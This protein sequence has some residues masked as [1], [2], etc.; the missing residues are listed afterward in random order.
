MVFVNGKAFVLSAVLTIALWPGI[1]GKNENDNS[2]ALWIKTARKLQAHEFMEICGD[3]FMSPDHMQQHSYLMSDFAD[4]VTNMCFKIAP[5]PDQGTC[6]GSGFGSLNSSLQNA[7]FRHA[8]QHMSKKQMPID[9]MMQ[10]GDA[11]YIVSDKTSIE[12]DVMR[13]DLCVEVHESIGD[14]F[15]KQI[16]VSNSP[17]QSGDEE[18]NVASEQIPDPDQVPDQVPVPVPDQVLVP[19]KT[20]LDVDKAESVFE[21]NDEKGFTM[22][23]IEKEEEEILSI[24]AIIAISCA[25]AAVIALFFYFEARRRNRARI[26]RMSRFNT[27]NKNFDEDGLIKVG[28]SFRMNTSTTIEGIKVAIN[29]AD[30]DCV[31]QL[32]SRIA[33]N[34]DGLSLPSLGSFKGQNRSHLGV[35]DQERTKTLDDLAANGDWTG[36]A[37][38]AALYAGETSSA[39][40]NQS[41]SVYSDDFDERSMKKDLVYVLKN[42]DIEEGQNSMEQMV[43]GLSR[44]LNA[45]NWSQVTRYANLIKDQKNSGSSF[46]TDSQV[47]L[48][49]P[50]ASSII[51][52]DTSNTEVSKKQTI[53]KLMQAGKWKGV[54]IM[55]NMYEMES[56]QGHP[57]SSV[58]P[59]PPSPPSPYSDTRSFART[60]EL[61]H[62]DRVQENIVGFR[63]DP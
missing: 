8:A 28:T 26:N 32:A 33:E 23:H 46:D 11:G 49:S 27:G 1:L 59:Y 2:T 37:V 16:P 18:Q 58:R 19:E 9:L 21:T 54:S 10:W 63:R 47:L 44:A 42:Q 4:E 38:T 24:S 50:S 56:K 34:D 53:A 55:A 35:E 43:S 17:N 6:L 31:Y 3:V 39:S 45:G 62:S 12:Q 5:N 25:V 40:H 22:V 7:F 29:N 14:E 61:R 51:S 60:K 57:S 48:T 52:T 30:W 36:L 41:N 15:I 20:N 13:N